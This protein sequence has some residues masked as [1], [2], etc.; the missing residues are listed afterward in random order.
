MC[1]HCGCRSFAPIAELTAEHEEILGVA[2][3][4]AEATRDQHAALAEDLR[5]LLAL[6]DVHANKEESGLY[7]ELLELGG[8]SEA[9]CSDLEEEHRATRA[10]L[11][12]GH[13]DRRRYY[14]LAAHI[15]VEELELF[16]AAR[17]SFDEPEWDSMA[18]AHDAVER[19]GPTGHHGPA[20]TAPDG[21]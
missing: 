17:F 1:D 19:A 13:F 21:R 12:S 2:W 9:E 8:L 4:L 15:E 3:T 14:A 7:P 16:P 18:A 20:A 5:R 6:L 10:S 11:V